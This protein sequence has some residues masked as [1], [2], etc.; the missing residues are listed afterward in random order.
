MPPHIDGS[1]RKTNAKTYNQSEGLMIDAGGQKIPVTG[2]PE[3]SPKSPSFRAVKGEYIV[4]QSDRMKSP[5][6]VQPARGTNLTSQGV[7]TISGGIDALR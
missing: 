6:K 7:R 2:S 4:E 3:K 5:G 1:P